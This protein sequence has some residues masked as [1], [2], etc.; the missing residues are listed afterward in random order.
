[1]PRYTAHGG[2]A[3]IPRQHVVLV[4][5]GGG[6]QRLQQQTG[7]GLRMLMILSSVVLLIACANIANLLLA[8]GVARRAELSVRM[9]LGAA[10]ARIIRQILTQS[11]LLSLIG[12]TA[13]LAVAYALSQM[14]LAACVSAG[15]QHARSGQSLAA[16]AWIC[17]PGVAAHRHH[18]RHRAGLAIVSSKSGGGVATAPTAAPAIARPFR[19]KL[20]S[21]FRWPCRLSCYRELFLWP[22]HLPTSSIRTSASRPPIVT[23]SDSIRKARATPSNVSPLFTARSKT[24]S[25]H[26]PP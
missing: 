9:A 5:G 3:L 6:I 10:R 16:R 13:G 22:G 15:A 24:A 25:P 26:C 17:I 4:P 12:G 19:R 2:A 18:L 7:Q 20:W 23:S 8:R 1:M 14:I 11:V 21:F